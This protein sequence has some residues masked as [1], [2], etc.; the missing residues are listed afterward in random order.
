MLCFKTG[1]LRPTKESD[2][3]FPQFCKFESK[4]FSVS[5]VEIIDSVEVYLQMLRNIFDFSAIKSLLTGPDQLKLHIDAMNGG[6]PIDLGYVLVAI[7]K[8]ALGI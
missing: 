2:L 1:S 8:L 5:P 6:G 7:Y 3:F 4:L